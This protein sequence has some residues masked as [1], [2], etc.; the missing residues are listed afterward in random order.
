MQLIPFFQKLQV[1]EFDHVETTQYPA[2]S[3]DF[4]QLQD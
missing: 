3:I 1:F 2:I 4:L